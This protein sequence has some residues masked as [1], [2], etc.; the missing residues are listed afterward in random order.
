MKTILVILIL[1]SAAL[2]QQPQRQNLDSN[3]I[4]P[5]G[6]V[7]S[8]GAYYWDIHNYG[9][10]SIQIAKGDSLYPI[11]PPEGT[12]NYGFTVDS[13]LI[14]PMWK[15]KPASAGVFYRIYR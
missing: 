1:A 4:S 3:Y 6:V 7:D 13:T 5:L 8:I 10:D 14:L 11:I 9:P 15:A 2:A 12:V